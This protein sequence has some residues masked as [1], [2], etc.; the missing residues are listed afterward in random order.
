[1]LLLSLMDS[2]LCVVRVSCQEV[3]LHVTS[4]GIHHHC[5]DRFFLR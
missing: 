5:W 1:M 3:D 4:K 2:I